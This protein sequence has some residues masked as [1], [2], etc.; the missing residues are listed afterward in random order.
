ET[1]LSVNTV[2]SSSDL[3][4]YWSPI[5]IDSVDVF[6]YRNCSDTLACPNPYVRPPFTQTFTVLVMN[7]DSCY[8]SDTVTVYVKNEPNAFIPTAFTP[9]G[10]GLNDRF[11]FD[12]LGAIT[13]EVSVFNRWGQRIY[14][15]A[16][17]P[18]GMS[19]D[20]G[21]DGTSKGKADPDDTYVY[22]LRINYYSGIKKDMS[23][24]ITL[25]R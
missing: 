16:A 1:Q 20:Y 5:A 19:N 13:V 4:Y 9:N 14:Y 2:P 22:Q 15:D 3:I 17:Q 10:D 18:N 8:A 6:D 25:M 7:S 23:G 21:W 12:I 24:T 11:T